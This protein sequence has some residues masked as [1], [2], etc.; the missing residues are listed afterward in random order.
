MNKQKTI[1]SIIIGGIF[2]GIVLTFYT[3][4]SLEEEYLFQSPVYSIK[5]NFIEGISPNTDIEL[6]YHYF[7]L[8]DCSLKVLTN[9][10]NELLSG[11]VPNGSK[12]L[13][14]NKEKQVI[15]TYTNIIKGDV[16]HDGI[17]DDQD[18]QL[19]GKYLIE[20]NMELPKKSIDINDDTE[21]H[22]NDIMLLDKTLQSDYQEL[23]LDQENLILQTNE[24]KRVVATVTPNYGKN[25][26]LI[27]NSLDQN[28]ATV[29]QSGKITGHQEG[30]TTILAETIDHKLTK[31]IKVKVDNTIQL[32][33][34]EGTG[35]I[36][37]KDVEVNIKSVDYEG[38]SCT[39]EKENIASCEIQNKKLILKPKQQGT[40]T[41]TVTSPKYGSVIYYLDVISVYLNVMPKYLCTTPRNVQM[42][43]VSAM[44]SGPYT[45]DIS[46]KDVVNHAE[47]VLYQ[48][49]KM[50]KI[51]MGDKFGRSTLTVKEG[52]GNQSN[53]V[54]IDTTTIAIPAIGGVGV[55]GTDLITTITGENLGTL[56]CSSS[57]ESKATCEI[58]EKQLI[59][60]P[61]KAGDV[62]ITV[63]NK[64]THRMDTY[65][66]GSATFLAVI[67][68]DTE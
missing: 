10:N 45:F 40:T 6:F 2:L 67:R 31:E 20:K 62:T 7:D 37:G 59:V 19:F 43:T 46:N 57:D 53:E 34:Y 29:D 32:S 56:S 58:R 49:R 61:M 8:E 51:T 22:L 44:N 15:A 48:G 5:D 27:W 28:I 33:A 12:T 3:T 66:C 26:N 54:T 68:E 13:L 24:T 9:G 65:D 25:T 63:K 11:Y 1:I 64:F 17:V 55:V 38:L 50:L 18:L 4:F 47:M 23:L 41:V 14:Y 30:E 36:G 60:H 16:T 42:I 52:N 39:M 21:I 35:Y